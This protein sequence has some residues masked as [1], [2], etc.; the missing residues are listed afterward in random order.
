MENLIRNNLKKNYFFDPKN[1]RFRLKTLFLLLFLSPIEPDLDHFLRGLP[2]ASK[3]VDFLKGEPGVHQCHTK[4]PRV[5]TCLQVGL[6]V[7]K[8]HTV[9]IVF[10]C[11]EPLK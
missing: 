10:S 9:E 6:N 2:V 7:S 1:R 5:L 4:P 3:G 11:H 8:G